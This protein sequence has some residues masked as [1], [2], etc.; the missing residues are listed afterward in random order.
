MRV[1]AAQVIQALGDEQLGKLPKVTEDLGEAAA[2][3]EAA[4]GDDAPAS[5]VPVPYSLAGIGEKIVRKLVDAGFGTQD[6]VAGASVDPVVQVV[7]T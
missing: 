3:V 7:L 6:A 4:V 2:D 1:D 5:D